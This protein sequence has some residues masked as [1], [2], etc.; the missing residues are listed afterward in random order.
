MHPN[1]TN[2]LLLLIPNKPAALALGMA[3]GP[4]KCG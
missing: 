1:D 3:I 2:C 4:L